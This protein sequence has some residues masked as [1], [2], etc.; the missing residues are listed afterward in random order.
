MGEVNDF[1]E[2]SRFIRIGKYLEL[3]TKEDFPFTYW[4][5]ELKS[6]DL[7]KCYLLKANRKK[8]FSFF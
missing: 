3:F 6:L 5:E 7:S 8:L 4:Y 2:G 1:D